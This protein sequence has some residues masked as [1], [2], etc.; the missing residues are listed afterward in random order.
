MFRSSLT[1]INPSYAA[2]ENSSPSR[3]TSVKGR[4]GFEYSLHSSILRDAP[5][6]RR[7][8]TFREMI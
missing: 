2:H 4:L 3:P 7:A 1:A 5:G 8:M 6:R